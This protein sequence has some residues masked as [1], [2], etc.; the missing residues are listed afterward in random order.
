MVS[1]RPKAASS[2]CGERINI[3]FGLFMNGEDALCSL[4]PD[5]KDTREAQ[6]CQ[7]KEVTF[8][9]AGVLSVFVVR[10]YSATFAFISFNGLLTSVFLEMIYGG[11]TR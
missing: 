2:I 8:V 6:R 4:L 9:Q 3:L 1:A 11:T 7:S 10:S 5:E